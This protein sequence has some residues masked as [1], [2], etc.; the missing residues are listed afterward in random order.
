MDGKDNKQSTAN[1]SAQKLGE[2]YSDFRLWNKHNSPSN[3]KVSCYSSERKLM[4]TCWYNSLKVIHRTASACLYTF[5]KVWKHCWICTKKRFLL[6][7]FSVWEKKGQV[8]I[9][10][11]H[12]RQKLLCQEHL[13]SEPRGCPYG[14]LLFWQ[15]SLLQ[16]IWHI[17]TV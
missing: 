6:C 2:A 1:R 7:G 13:P 17:S 16:C 14:G 3:Y 5:L 4:F 10:E 15:R 12:I 11:Y 9:D 8:K